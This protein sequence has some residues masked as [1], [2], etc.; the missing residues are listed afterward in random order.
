MV[1]L[2]KNYGN[3]IPLKEM[4]DGQIA[5]IVEYPL[6]PS[7][8]GDIVMRHGDDLL[9]VGMVEGCSW[10]GIFDDGSIDDRDTVRLLRDDEPLYVNNDKLVE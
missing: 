4:K 6:S 10:S 9:V 1:R 8:I 3:S 5:E 7:Y 2:K